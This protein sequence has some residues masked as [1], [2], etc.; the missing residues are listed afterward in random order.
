MT[1]KNTISVSEARTRFLEIIRKVEFGE[2]IMITKRGD[3]VAKIVP[4]NS[5]PLFGFAPNVKINADLSLPLDLSW[6]EAELNVRK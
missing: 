2:T 5:I 4:T 1:K 6:N 3:L